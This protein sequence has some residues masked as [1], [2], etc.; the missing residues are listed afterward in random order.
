MRVGLGHQLE[1]RAAQQGRP[2]R[3]YRVPPRMS[4]GEAAR[5]RKQVFTIDEPEDIPYYQLLLG[6]LDELVRLAGGVNVFAD[7]KLRYAKIAVES[8]EERQPEVIL[9]VVHIEVGGEESGRAD[10]L[11][12]S[13][14]AGVACDKGENSAGFLAKALCATISARKKRIF[15]MF[16]MWTICVYL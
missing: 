14:R 1:R 15:L 7:L 8:L 4:A 16:M 3:V 12:S 11:D 5:W 10:W 6:D 2:V 9:D 13:C